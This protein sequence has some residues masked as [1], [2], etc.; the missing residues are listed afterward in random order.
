MCD[1][2]DNINASKKCNS[3]FLRRPPRSRRA[4]NS[5]PFNFGDWTELCKNVSTSAPKCGL[6]QPGSSASNS[7]LRVRK[8]RLL[9]CKIVKRSR[10]YLEYLILK[11]LLILITVQ[12]IIIL[13]HNRFIYIILN[14]DKY[15]LIIMI[16]QINNE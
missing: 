6:L 12:K 13:L 10:K 7:A 3:S 9:R 4:T 14:C 16:A 11:N 2:L 5:Y 1:I 8:P 15:N